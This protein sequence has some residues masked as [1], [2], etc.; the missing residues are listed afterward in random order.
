[1]NLIPAPLAAAMRSRNAWPV[2]MVPVGLAGLAIS[3]PLS[4]AL[5]CAASSISG[6]IAQRVACVVSITTGSQPSA[7][8]MCR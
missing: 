3:T 5:R 2:I 8:R 4:G 7:V 6:V 1:M